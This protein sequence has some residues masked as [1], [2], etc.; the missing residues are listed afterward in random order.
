[1]LFWGVVALIVQLLVFFIVR[2]LFKGLSDAIREGVVSKGLF[3]G[4]LSL[5]AGIL[6]AACIS[7]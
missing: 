5:A 6:N 3:L 7:Y 1:M 2:M 4:A